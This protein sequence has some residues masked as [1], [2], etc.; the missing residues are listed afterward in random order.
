LRRGVL[1]T[2]GRGRPESSQS[3]RTG[4]GGGSARQ[5]ENPGAYSSSHPLD[6]LAHSL[7]PMHVILMRAQRTCDSLRLTAGFDLP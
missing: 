3:Y 5:D 2:G 1:L 7:P 6:L 4:Y